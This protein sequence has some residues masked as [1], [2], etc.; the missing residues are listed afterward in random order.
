MYTIKAIKAGVAKL[1]WLVTTQA[2]DDYATQVKGN[3]KL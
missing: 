1:G 2:H 3:G